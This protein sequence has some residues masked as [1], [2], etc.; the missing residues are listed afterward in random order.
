[1]T[2]GFDKVNTHLVLVPVLA[3]LQYVLKTLW[4]IVTHLGLTESESHPRK[5]A[6]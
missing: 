2:G 1:M 6:T 5:V 3:I 4:P